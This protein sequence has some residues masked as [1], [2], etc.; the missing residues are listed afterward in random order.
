MKRVKKKLAVLLIFAMAFS[1]TPQS[2]FAA[3]KKVKL[4]KNKVTVKVGQ[5]ITVK[6]KN[7]KKKVKWSISSGKKNVALSK[8]KKTSVMIRGRKAGKAKVQA[9]VGKKKYVCQVTVQAEKKENKTVVL[10]P[11]AAASQ[12][13]HADVTKAPLSHVSEAPKGP[14]TSA[15][16]QEPAPTASIPVSPVPTASAPETP[17]PAPTES[18]PETP[19]PVPEESA[20]PYAK[21]E[22]LIVSSVD[23]D[24]EIDRYVLDQNV[25]YV[26]KA[27]A[28]SLKDIVPDVK[29]CTYTVYSYGRRAAVKEISDIQW[30]DESYYDGDDEDDGYYTFS[31]TVESEGKE[32]TKTITIARYLADFDYETMYGNGIVLTAVIADG[33]EY[34][35]DRSLYSYDLPGYFLKDDAQSAKTIYAAAEKKAV[36]YYEDQKFVWDIAAMECDED[37][38]GIVTFKVKG[39]EFGKRKMDSFTVRVSSPFDFFLEVVQGSSSKGKITYDPE[40]RYFI[41]DEPLG[42]GKT[43]QDIFTDVSAD[44]Q[45]TRVIYKNKYIDNAEIRN[46]T[47]ND[48]PYYDEEVDQGYYSFDVVVTENGKEVSQ[49]CKLVEKKIEYTVSG[50]LTDLDGQPIANAEMDIYR[51][52]SD[53]KE[54]TT[55]KNGQYSVSLINGTYSFGGMGDEFVVNGSDVK[56]DRKLPVYKIYGN[57][58]RE[59]GKPVT[60]VTIGI[61]SEESET[62]YCDNPF[63]GTYYAYLQEGTYDVRLYDSFSAASITVT[64]SGKLDIILQVGK[65][66]GKGS[67]F[68]TFTDTTDKNNSCHAYAPNTDYAIYLKPGTYDVIRDNIVIDTIEVTYGDLEKNYEMHSCQG[69]ILDIS[70]KEIPKNLY[71]NY[72][73]LVKR[74]GTEYTNFTL[75]RK[76]EGESSGYSMEL[77]DGEYEFF[78]GETSVGKVTVS[79][80]D[81]V[82]DLTMPLKYVTINFLDKE[83]K[84]IHL[85]Q[86]VDLKDEKEKKFY[87]LDDDIS[88]AAAVLPV[89]TYQCGYAPGMPSMSGQTFT[90]TADSD[91]VTVNT[92]WYK[93][94]GR[95]Q[96]NGQNMSDDTW[97]H[98]RTTDGKT[99]T[100]DTLK[101]GVFTFY[102]EPGEYVLE[103]NGNSGTLAEETIK[104]ENASIVKDFSF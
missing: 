92:N 79:G 53:Y 23:F 38:E 101:D 18:A 104:V 17:A 6:L 55:D 13:P 76:Y 90:V 71:N 60:D 64:G 5:K 33:V 62:L 22:E 58:S 74:N 14:A 93:L 34:E 100:S 69:I 82:K 31:M 72:E 7:N 102:V 20:S 9:K 44:L 57:V 84:Q 73:I 65:V 91:T 4:N 19:E 43:L 3:K 35:V 40:E 89:G 8:K 61:T 87:M 15:P 10:A 63:D 48:E 52:G 21:T 39:F 41:Y 78:Y 47:W 99:S 67:G 24:Q 83:N 26:E 103:I 94:S 70:G 59:G 29:K 54:I 68:Y 50:T 2:A 30:H 51:E 95:C 96:L 12:A 42:E 27:G 36:F 80:K 97:V 75:F 46:V 1:V 28:A 25:I 11:T 56:I 85:T 88:T 45:I 32:Y 49:E 37:D 81:V 77:L 66:Y 86:S 16:T 98:L